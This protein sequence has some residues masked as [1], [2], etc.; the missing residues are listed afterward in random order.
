MTTGGGEENQKSER[1]NKTKFTRFQSREKLPARGSCSVY[2]GPI[3]L[4][5]SFLTIFYCAL[6]APPSPSVTKA[7]ASRRPRMLSLLW[8]GLLGEPCDI[9]YFCFP[10]LQSHL[11]LTPD[12]CIMASLHL[13]SAGIQ[14]GGCAAAATGACTRGGGGLFG[15]DGVRTPI[16]NVCLCA[17]ARVTGG[18]LNDFRLNLAH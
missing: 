13:L 8:R 14:G 17:C 10:S 12:I 15:C 9:Q 6:S 3:R 4:K 11:H 5:G 2:P 18:G 7:P 1:R 16:R